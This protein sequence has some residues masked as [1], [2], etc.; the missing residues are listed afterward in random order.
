MHLLSARASCYLPFLK[1]LV[2][3][4]AQASPCTPCQCTVFEEGREA[5]KESA[6][7][8]ANQH[9]FA[10]V[11]YDNPE[12]CRQ[13]L[14]RVARLCVASVDFTPDQITLSP[15]ERQTIRASVAVE[16]SQATFNVEMAFCDSEEVVYRM[17]EAHSRFDDE[18]R[19]A[20]IASHDVPAVYII[21]FCLQDPFGF[22]RP[23]YT[24][25]SVCDEDPAVPCGDGQL[26]IV[27]NASGNLSL[28]PAPVA[29][30]LE[31]VRS[32]VVDS[33]DGLVTSLDEAVR[34][35]QLDT[36]WA[37]SIARHDEAMANSLRKGHAQGW[38][39]GRRDLIAKLVDLGVLAN[40]EAQS[41][42]QMA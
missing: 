23:I 16:G 22:N 36:T 12:L 24:F 4:F 29:T 8:L 2:S 32:G 10:K 7:C 31:Y 1:R 3:A 17:R 27:L 41:L 5:M 42:A 33:R 14:E 19:K 28:A 38:N 18:L 34:N 37:R 6:F 39:E 35:L 11:L 13:T 20:G 15:A 26:S 9:V 30:L 40:D 21:F 25:R